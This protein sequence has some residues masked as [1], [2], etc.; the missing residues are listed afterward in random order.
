MLK[1]Y[2]SDCE[3][4]EMEYQGADQEQCFCAFCP[5]L[6]GKKSFSVRPEERK[7][8][9]WQNVIEYTAH[10]GFLLRMSVKKVE[11]CCRRNKTEEESKKSLLF[12]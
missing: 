7:I 5:E 4:Q 10:E 9:N 3:I 6:I 2:C 8:E 11:K 1:K 12:K